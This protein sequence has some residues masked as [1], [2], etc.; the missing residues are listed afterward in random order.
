MAPTPSTYKQAARAILDCGLTPNEVQAEYGVSHDDC[1]RMVQ[2]GL[3]PFLGRF[4][5]YQYIISLKTRGTPWPTHHFKAIMRAK[6][7]CDSG[8]ANLTCAYGP[9]TIV[10]YSFPVSVKQFRKPWF[11]GMGEG[12]E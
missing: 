2:E 10:M 8:K 9:E 11:F 3:V 4:E 7:S 5:D 6:E 12:H 1:Q